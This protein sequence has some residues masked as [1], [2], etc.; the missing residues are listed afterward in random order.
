MKTLSVIVLLLL[1][2]ASAVA[3]YGT[4]DIAEVSSAVSHARA[5]EPAQLLLCGAVL[6][7]MSVAVRRASFVVHR[8]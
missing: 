2:T 7:A 5:T 4:L 1:V 6:L 8:R 3:A